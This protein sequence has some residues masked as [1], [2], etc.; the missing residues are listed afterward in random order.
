[1]SYTLDEMQADY[2]AAEDRILLKL[3]AEKTLWRVWLTRRF[4]RL[5]LPFLHGIHPETGEAFSPLPAL[6]LEQAD[7]INT[8]PDTPLERKYAD[9]ILETP[10]GDAPIL[11][12]ELTYR[13]P[14]PGQSHGQMVLKPAQGE[15][16]VLPFAPALNH[17]LIK[18]IG[19]AVERADWNL[20]PVDYVAVQSPTAAL[21]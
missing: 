14:G 1:M 9:T 20:P 21:Q 10:L 18:L 16:I 6:P 2:V 17:A 15:G 5:L 13:P 8:Q 3:R 12:V 7:R 11:L 4:T 19:A